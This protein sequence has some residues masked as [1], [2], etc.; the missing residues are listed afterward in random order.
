MSLVNFAKSELEA[1]GLFAKDSDYEG[2]LGNTVFELITLFAEQGHSGGSAEMVTQLFEKLA[3]FKPLTP[4]TGDDSEWEL[5]AGDIFQ[6]R[7]CSSVFK[8]NGVTYDIHGKVFIELSGSSYTSHESRVTVTFPYS[9]KTEFVRVETQGGPAMT[10]TDRQSGILNFIR[11]YLET[12]GYAPTIEEIRVSCG[13]SSKSVVHY[14]LKRL[15]E[16]GWIVLGPPN[17]ARTIKV[18]IW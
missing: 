17:T 5:V 2:M 9:P 12:H 18:V 15:A 4:L 7:R 13:I 11:L 16:Q 3:R 6:N 14:N 10:M 8:E 1:A